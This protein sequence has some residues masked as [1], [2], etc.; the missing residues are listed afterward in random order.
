MPV[1]PDSK[2][3]DRIVKSIA[4]EE[5]DPFTPLLDEYLIKRNLPKYQDRRLKE[6]TLDLRERPRPIGRLSPSSICGCERQAAF[7]FLGTEGKRRVDPDQE[8]LFIDGHW[9]HHKWQ[10]L[11]YDMEA[12]LGRKRFRVVHIEAPMVVED[13]CIAGNLDIEVEVKVDGKWI[14]YVIDFKGANTFAFDRTYR[15]QAPDATYV[16]QLI[17]YLAGRGKKRG[18]LLYD[19]KNTNKTACYVVTMNDQQWGEIQAWCRRVLDQV[20]AKELPPIHP[21]CNNGTFLY[22]RCQYRSLCFGKTPPGQLTREVYVDFPGVKKLWK[23]G[24]K[25][26]ELYGE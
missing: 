15:E 9:R 24:L 12:V 26:I 1:S 4:S 25:E 7:K 18:I 11:F 16:K 5:E 14:S 21:D 10:T 2:I 23:R 19:S 22:N 20:K 13:L 17:T 6:I 8:L 3:L